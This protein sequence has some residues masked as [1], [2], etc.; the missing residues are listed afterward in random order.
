MTGPGTGG[1]I[2]PTGALVARAADRLRPGATAVVAVAGPVAVGKSTLAGLLAGALRDR[3]LGAE[4]VSTDGFLLPGADLAARGLTLRKGFPESYDV[5]A[6]RAFCA[7][8]RDTVG[9]VDPVGVPVYSHEIYD[10]VPGEFRRVPPTDV[11]VLEG[12]NALSATGGCTDLGIYVDAPLPVVEQWFVERF[13]RLVADARTDATSFYARFTG[14]TPAA[15]EEMARSVY[16]DVNLPNL[17]EHIAPSR[18][19]AE[20]VVHKGADHS[21]SAIV[22]RGAAP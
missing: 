13:L 7:T 1:G 21:W 17:T 11:V 15:Q 2:D 19:L 20:V 3:G 12:L 14:L 8:V 6:L 9:R 16:R 4:V 22:D 10:I 18:A 5:T